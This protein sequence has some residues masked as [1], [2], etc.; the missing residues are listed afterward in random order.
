MEPSAFPEAFEQRTGIPLPP[1]RVHRLEDRLVRADPLFPTVAGWAFDNPAGLA[2]LRAWA[3][4]W[5][6]RAPQCST[7]ELYGYLS[8]LEEDWLEA[9]RAF[10]RSLALESENLDAWLDLAFSLRHLG[11]ALGDAIL[12][13]H[14]EFIRLC[15][16]APP[17][18]LD[19]FTLQ[20]LE[21]RIRAEGRSWAQVHPGAI[22]PYRAA[23]RD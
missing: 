1:R 3:R 13:D 7:W 6:E 22:E 9:A 2:A 11:L 15:Q 14:T 10:M 21:R 12:W 23:L 4:G 20:A 19:L 5:T 16:E 17:A 8:Y 18:R